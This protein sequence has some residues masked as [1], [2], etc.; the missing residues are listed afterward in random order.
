M[1]SAIVA[2]TLQNGIPSDLSWGQCS[3]NVQ[4][5]FT[6]LQNIF[7]I[8]CFSKEVQ[9]NYGG[10]AYIR[11]CSKYSVLII[12]LLIGGK[13]GRWILFF[14][15]NCSHEGQRVDLPWRKETV[16]LPEFRLGSR[17]SVVMIWQMAEKS[18]KE[19]YPLPSSVFVCNS[20][21]INN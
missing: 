2:T 13:G 9:C 12:Y 1:A 18:E 8:Y 3:G 7:K 20:G 5:P 16:I 10:N 15:R 19:R 4:N 17:V 21:Q 14:L 6:F 11:S